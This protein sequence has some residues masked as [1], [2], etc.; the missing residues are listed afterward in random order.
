MNKH[1]WT[2]QE[3]V[4]VFDGYLKRESSAAI[5]KETGI[6]ETSVKMKLANFKYLMTGSG[7]ENCSKDSIRVVEEHNRAKE[8]KAPVTTGNSY[9]FPDQSMSKAVKNRFDE[10]DKK[11]GAEIKDLSRRASALEMKVVKLE[12][13]I[14]ESRTVFFVGTIAV[15]FLA[16]AIILIQGV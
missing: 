6:S 4:R 15:I 16:A 14:K 1:R 10:L 2:Y 13:N 3:N 12:G 11:R 5:A 9:G 8:P 7:L